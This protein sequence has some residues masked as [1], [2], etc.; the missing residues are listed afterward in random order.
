MFLETTGRVV[1]QAAMKEL[2]NGSIDTIVESNTIFSAMS[3]CSVVLK[4]RPNPPSIRKQNGT[5]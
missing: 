1:V 2:W 4:S 3:A 5:T